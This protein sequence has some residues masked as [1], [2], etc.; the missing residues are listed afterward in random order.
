[1]TSGPSLTSSTAPVTH[2]NAALNLWLAEEIIALAAKN[3]R[4][5]TKLLKELNAAGRKTAFSRVFTMVK[6]PAVYCPLAI[7]TSVLLKHLYD[8]RVTYAGAIN[9]RIRNLSDWV[10]PLFT[11]F[12][13]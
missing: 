1:M 6:H 2:G 13:K 12:T 5:T 4:M 11:K 10:G 9:S 3:R 7:L 8:N